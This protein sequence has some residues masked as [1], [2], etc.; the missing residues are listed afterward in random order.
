MFGDFT[1]GF[2]VSIYR[3]RIEDAPKPSMRI[4]T[5]DAP[6]G[7]ELP[8]DGLPHF[9]GRPAKFML[10]LLATWATM[11]FRTPKIVGAPD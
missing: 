6:E 7:V 8:N 10:K 9:R 11:G 2:W 5:S 4:M 1:R 3:D